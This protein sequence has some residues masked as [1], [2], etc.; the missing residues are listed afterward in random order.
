MC[1]ALT[2][3][4]ILTFPISYIY[5]SCWNCKCVRTHFNNCIHI[6]PL[7]ISLRISLLISLCSAFGQMC[8]A[9]GQ[10]CTHLVK[11]CAFAQMARVSS[12]GQM[13]SAFNALFKCAVHLSKAHVR[14][15]CRNALRICPNALRICPYVRPSVRPHLHL[16]SSEQ[17]CSSGGRGMLT[18]LSLCYSIV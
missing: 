18:E 2:Y 11:R 9:I 1:P 10:M 6:W 7:L 16:A 5:W 8:S 14:C 15:I 13:R 12:I 4:L 3:F 17:W